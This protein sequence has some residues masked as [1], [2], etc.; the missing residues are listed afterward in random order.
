MLVIILH[1]IY[2]KTDI[3]GEF[4]KGA[5]ENLKTCAELVPTLIALITAVGMLRSSGAEELLLG[6]LSGL[7]E[8]AGFP[9]QCLPLA[10][11]R[12]LSG[13][14][15][16]AVYESIIEA[17]GPDST[18]GRTASV[19][20]GSTETTFYTLAVYFGAVNIKK[21]RHTLGASLTGD[22]T[23]FIISLLTVNILFRS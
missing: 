4:A 15:A 22:I 7:T 19:M 11:I 12:P 20:M 10:L 14:G 18:A 17:A 6:A 13:S 23:G 3:F 16:L 21:T 9:A 1:G 5:S 2:K 8:R